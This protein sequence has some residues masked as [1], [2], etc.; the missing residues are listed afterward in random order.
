[1]QL[2]ATDISALY[3]SHSEA[4]WKSAMRRTFDAQASVDVVGET[5]AVAFEQRRRHRGTSEAEASSWLFGIATNLLKQYFRSGAIER[6]AM[7]RLGVDQRSLRPTSSSDGRW[8]SEAD[9]G[10][11]C[12]VC[13]GIGPGPGCADPRPHY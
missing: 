9:S 4:I 7:E 3:E 2:T 13:R 8:H 11:A 1:M 12:C 5:F 6:R 10:T